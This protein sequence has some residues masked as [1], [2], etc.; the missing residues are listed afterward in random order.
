MDLHLII[1][2]LAIV[3]TFFVAF[4]LLGLVFKLAVFAFENP[5]TIL[6]VLI[7]CVALIAYAK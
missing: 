1:S 7:G 2:I 6:L 5:F 3:I 4:A